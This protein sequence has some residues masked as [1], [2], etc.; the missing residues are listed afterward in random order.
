MGA[1]QSASHGDPETDLAATKTCY[2]ELIG[3]DRDASE[4][5]YVGTFVL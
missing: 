5:E 4:T 3:V 2:Y 1:S